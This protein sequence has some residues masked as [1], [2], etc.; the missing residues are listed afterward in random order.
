MDDGQLGFI[1]SWWYSGIGLPVPLGTVSNIFMFKTQFDNEI[2]AIMNET[3][4]F[5]A[6]QHCQTANVAD[7]ANF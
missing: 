2:N 1:S 5:A 6:C 4:T 3:A 7:K